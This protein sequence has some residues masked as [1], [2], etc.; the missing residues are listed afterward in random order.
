MNKLF[1]I[2]YFLFTLTDSLDRSISSF[3]GGPCAYKKSPY[4]IFTTIKYG[5][6]TAR[7]SYSG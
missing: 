2:C 6:S 5:L 3:F 4:L 1:K 7:L